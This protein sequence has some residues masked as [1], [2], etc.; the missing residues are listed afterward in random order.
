MVGESQTFQGVFGWSF[1][2]AG[3]VGESTKLH[4]VFG[5]WPPSARRRRLQYLNTNARGSTKRRGKGGCV[6]SLI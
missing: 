5:V 4:G 6:D 3:V 1:G 2:N